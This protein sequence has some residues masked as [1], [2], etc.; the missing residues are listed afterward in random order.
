VKEIAQIVSYELQ[1]PRLALVTVT[2]VR[3]AANLKSA[4]IYVTI[5]GNE[6]DHTTALAALR[7]A[8]PYLRK[9]LGLSLNIPTYSRSFIL[10]ATELKKRAN[11]WTSYW[12]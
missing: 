11:V 1:D 12:Q 2:D 9:E 3:M 8:V 10:C 4:K 7:H 6:E 5:A